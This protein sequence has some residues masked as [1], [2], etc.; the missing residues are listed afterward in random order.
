MVRSWKTMAAA[1]AVAIAAPLGF[2][3]TAPAS[4][5][6]PQAGIRS[7]SSP[8]TVHAII[9]TIALPLDGRAVGTGPDLG[10]SI[11]IAAGDNFGGRLLQIDPVTLL[12]TARVT[13]G[14][15]PKGLAVSADDTIYVVNADSDTLSVIRGASMTTAATVSVPDE[16]QAVGLSRVVDDT[17]FISSSGTS[18]KIAT[19]DT[20]SLTLTS[21]TALGMGASPYGLA[22]ASDDSV[23][24]SSYGGN[25]IRLFDPKTGI[26]S[27]ATTASG[28]IGVAIS[29]DDTVYYSNESGNT[30][31]GFK[32]GIPGTQTSVAVT[33][34]Q[35][36]AVSYDDTI[37]VAGRS[38]SRIFVIDPR[39][40]AIDDSVALGGQALSVAVTRSGLVVTANPYAPT[41]WVIAAVTPS[42]TTTSALAG[43]TGSLAIN[44]LPAGV[45]IDDTTVLS[46]K[47]G[48][49]TVAW[50]RTPGTNTLTGPIPAGSGTVAVTVSFK[51]G[52]SAGA[53]N[54]TYATPA[55]PPAPTYYPPSEPTGVVAVAGDA[56]ADVS[57]RAPVD[58][59]SYPIAEYEVMS[60]PGSRTCTVAAPALTCQIT[61]LTNGTAYTFKARAR[62]EVGWGLW[63]LPS[64]GVTPEASPS[65]PRDVIATA[66]DAQASVAWLAPIDP[67]S[68]AIL[69]YEVQ[70]N[71]AGG[72]CKT[73]ALTC[74]VTGLTNGTAYTFIA[75]AR[76]NNGWGPW[77][78]ASAAITPRAPT[79][80][81]LITGTR[82]DVNGKS[83]VIVTGTSTHL[84]TGAILRPW[85][86]F[87]GERSYTKGAAS[88]LVNST[89]AFTWER[90]TGK[91]IYVYVATD[92]GTVKSNSV[93][94]PVAR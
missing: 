40:F 70:S 72:S 47:F 28:P 9:R 31:K 23:Y 18:N 10:D 66:G 50:T 76:N 43:A 48:D 56:R 22:V 80:T 3:T 46:V 39:T 26:V 91:K 64:G 58:P 36:V 33:D 49:D 5:A 4:S 12:E 83:G 6:V 69:E 20:S 17:V 89:G 85:L 29:R 75:R 82:G 74:Q 90:R 25:K 11:Y 77:S 21:Q 19:V 68:S 84:G 73:T 57:W 63:S 14:N 37:Y 44:G 7:V 52:N 30:V 35:G 45:I 41:A 67:G 61:G 92:D 71:P 81:I 34:P 54:F 53:G 42:L 32:S 38:S 51:G 87:P 13:V 78:S 15:Y 62:N 79:P 88:I 55:P 27:D 93:V 1:S 8:G 24:V 65:A 16:P 94:V 2:G 59:G 60:S 86:R